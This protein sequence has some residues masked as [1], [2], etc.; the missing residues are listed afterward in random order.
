MV[1][2]EDK[3]IQWT[4]AGILYIFLFVF[5]F[6]LKNGN[7]NQ[8]NLS[9]TFFKL[10]SYEWASF[11]F[12]ILIGFSAPDY[13]HYLII[14][15]ILWALILKYLFKIN[16]DNLYYDLSGLIIGYLLYKITQSPQGLKTSPLL[17]VPTLRQ[18]IFQSQQPNPWKK[19][20]NKI[21]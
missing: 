13:L 9:K 1:E 18:G 8:S 2:I 12:R 20:Y 17:I 15:E 11:I 5:T 19:Y 4:N 7:Y 3:T 16:L 10:T 21:K 14:G 6:I